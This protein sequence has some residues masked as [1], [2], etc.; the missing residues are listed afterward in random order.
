MRIAADATPVILTTVI[1]RRD[2]QVDVKK[3]RGPSSAGAGWS[4]EQGANENLFQGKPDTTRSLLRTS[5][6][7]GRL[8]P[9]HLTADQIVAWRYDG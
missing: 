1:L 4:R 6:P 9:P 3:P 7:I 2:H 8:H 5:V